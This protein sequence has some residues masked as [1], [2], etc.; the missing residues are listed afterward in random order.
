MSGHIYSTD[1]CAPIRLCLVR[2]GV[3]SMIQSFNQLLGLVVVISIV[4]GSSADAKKF[5]EQQLRLVSEMAADLCGKLV[6][7]K[8][9]STVRRVEVDASIGEYLRK[10]LG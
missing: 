7:F 9:E 3:F 10:L 5:N 6:E 2:D 4:T 1:L 8:G